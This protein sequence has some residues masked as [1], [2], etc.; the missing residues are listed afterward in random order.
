MDIFDLEFYTSF[1]VDLQDE[2]L[3]TSWDSRSVWYTW[4]VHSECNSPHWKKERTTF[5]QLQDL[6]LTHFQFPHRL[7]GQVD[8][9]VIIFSWR[10]RVELC[11]VRLWVSSRLDDRLWVRQRWSKSWTSVAAFFPS[12]DLVKWFLLCE[13]PGWVSFL[14]SFPQKPHC[15]S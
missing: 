13:T 5:G 14:W 1:L 9:I 10:W 6:A 7:I 15:V 4:W 3:L 12:K 8:S 11:W 2:L